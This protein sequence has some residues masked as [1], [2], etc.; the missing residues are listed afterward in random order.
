MTTV[1]FRSKKSAAALIARLKQDEHAP[2][3]AMLEIADR[4]NEVCVH[5]YQV[6]GQKGEIRT[7]DWKQILDELAEMG[8][9]FLTVSGGEATLRKDFLEIVEHA[10]KRRFAVKIFTNGLTMSRELAN[11][12]GELA[13]QEVQISLYSHRAEVHDGITRVPGSWERTVNGAR[14]LM[15]AGC[16]VLLKT[17]IMSVNADD[18]DAYID[19][20]SGLGADYMLDPHIDPRE[21]GDRSTESL[22]IDDATYLRAK[23]NPRLNGRAHA[24]GSDEL[25]RSVCGACSGNVHV[26]AN[27]EM[28]PCTQLGVP[29]GNALE[30][31]REAWKRNEAGVAIRQLTW[32]DLHGC[33]ECDLRAYCSRCF[34]NAQVEA[35]DALGPYESAC[36][37]AKLQYELVHGQ[38][39]R[40]E[41]GAERNG[42]IGPYRALEGAFRCVE[43][44]VRDSDR[45]LARR[46]GWIRPKDALV[47]LGIRRTKAAPAP[48]RD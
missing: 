34:A 27:G 46:H 33:R 48:Q 8:V 13:V 5:C 44:V 32:A 29:V 41:P 4:C 30:G 42:A 14:Y 25:D 11:R 31:V 2:M 28:R 47:Q 37:R 26:E 43:D 23:N 39:P 19:F 17:P 40:I 35:G 36:H 6:Q 10:R 3:S 20:V 12:L 21:D 22:R 1:P 9:L 7:E 38:P 16:H 45:E 18:V 15:E 24:K